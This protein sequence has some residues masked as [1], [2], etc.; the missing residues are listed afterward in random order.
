MNFLAITITNPTKKL[1]IVNQKS[2]KC[3]FNERIFFNLHWINLIRCLSPSRK[4]RPYKIILYLPMHCGKQVAFKFSFPRPRRVRVVRLYCLFGE[5]IQ[6]HPCPPFPNVFTWDMC[7]FPRRFGT[8]EHNIFIFM[9]RDSQGE[10]KR[11]GTR[12]QILPVL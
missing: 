6:N 2:T 10:K 4:T 3:G 8:S 7:V 9:F 11:N 5:Q 1:V 12:R